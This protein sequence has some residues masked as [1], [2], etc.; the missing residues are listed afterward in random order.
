MNLDEWLER[1]ADYDTDG[2]C[3]NWC[4]HATRLLGHSLD[5]Y[6]DPDLDHWRNHNK[7][8]F[9]NHDDILITP[10]YIQSMGYRFKI[11]RKD[12]YDGVWS[13]M[14]ANDCVTFGVYREGY[15]WFWNRDNGVTGVIPGKGAIMSFDALTPVKGIL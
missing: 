5:W 2:N 4:V 14:L 11:V 1:I 12:F 15:S 9:R 7:P 6:D 13:M 8:D 3:G 10:C